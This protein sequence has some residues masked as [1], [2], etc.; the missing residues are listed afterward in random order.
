MF[1]IVLLVIV[2]KIHPRMNLL[3]VPAGYEYNSLNE[4][5]KFIPSALR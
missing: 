2:K 3:K 5:I 4:T 1:L